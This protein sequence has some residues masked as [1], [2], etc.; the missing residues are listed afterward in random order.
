ML[1]LLPIRSLF[2]L[3]HKDTYGKMRIVFLLISIVTFC[4]CSSIHLTNRIA[5]RQLDANS[6]QELNGTYL[7]K[8]LDTIPLGST[9]FAHFKN[10]K[11]EPKYPRKY[12]SVTLTTIDMKTLGVKLLNNDTIVDSLIVKGKYKEG[13]FKVRRRWLANFFAGALIWGIGDDFKY[14]GL[15]KENNLI[16]LNSSDA[17]MFITA[18]PVFIFSG[19]FE[20][21]YVRVK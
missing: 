20:D 7:N 12:A 16:I 4:S 18:V 8:A 14:L 9:L 17:V 19:E 3:T 21:E 1:K 15:T 11:Y 10:I 2:R 6:F 13:Y 5:D